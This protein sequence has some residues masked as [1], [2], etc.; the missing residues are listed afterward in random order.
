M[1]MERKVEDRTSCWVSLDV[2]V[3]L[4]R[5]GLIVWQEWEGVGPR[6]TREEWSAHWRTREMGW[7]EDTGRQGQ[8][9]QANLAM[10]P[11]LPLPT[12]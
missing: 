7:E 6:G 2:I 8:L 10:C 9:S 5:A 4:T 12:I 1:V 11:A 3:T